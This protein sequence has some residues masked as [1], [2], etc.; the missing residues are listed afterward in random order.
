MRGRSVVATADAT[1]VPAG[2]A[3]VQ[4]RRLS[5]GFGPGRRY[6][7][8]MYVDGPRGSSGWKTNVKV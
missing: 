7:L 8:Q 1:N 2:M 6:L 4:L 3:H 5:P